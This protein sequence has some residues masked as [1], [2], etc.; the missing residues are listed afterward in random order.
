MKHFTTLIIAT[1]F[2]MYG[3]AQ[4]TYTVPFTMDFENPT[5]S[6]DWTMAPNTAT[7]YWM[8]GSATGNPGNS[9]YITN[10]GTANAYTNTVVSHST[11]YFTV[12][13]GN[14]FPEYSI[15]FDWAVMA[16]SANWDRVEAFVIPDTMTVPATWG[17]L[18]NNWITGEG[19]IYLGVFFGQAAWQRST[20]YI[21]SSYVAN[22]TKKVVFMFYCDNSG[23]SNPVAIDNISITGNSC[24]TPISVAVSDIGLTTAEISWTG[25]AEAAWN[26]IISEGPIADFTSY[27]VTA[28]L[29][30]P[31]TATSLLPSTLYYVYVQ[32]DCGADGTSNWTEAVTFYTLC[33]AVTTLPYMDNFDSYAQGTKPYCWTVVD[34]YDGFPQVAINANHSSPNSIQFNGYGVQTIATRAFDAEVNTMEVTFWLRMANASAGTFEV[35]VMSDVLDPTTFEPIRNITPAASGTTWLYI[36]VQ[37]NNALSGNHF[38][39]L[40]QTATAYG[41]YYIDDV[42][43][44]DLPACF[45]PTNVSVPVINQTSA[46]ITWTAGASESAWDVIISPTA[47]SDLDNVQAIGVI[48]PYY[49]ATNLSPSIVY[50]VYVRA[51]CGGGTSNWTSAVAFRTLCGAVTTLPWADNFD[52]YAATNIPACWTQ[53]QANA[54]YP[55]VALT[56]HSTPNGLQFNGNTQIIATPGFASEANTLEVGFW[57]R[58]GTATAGTFEVGVMSDVLDQSTFVPIRDVTPAT[59][60]ATWFYFEVQLNNAVNG[61]HFIAFKQTATATASYYLDDV[62]V[63]ELP[64]CFKPT[65]VTVSNIDQASVDIGWAAGISSETAWNVVISTSPVTDFTA[66]SPIA[67]TIPYYSPTDLSP[68][69]PYYV[70][71]QANCG[72]A[73]GTSDWT[74]AIAFRTLCGTVTSAFWSDNFDSYTPSSVPDCWT[75]I[76]TSDGFPR[77]I[78]SDPLNAIT[79]SAPYSLQFNGGTQIIATPEFAEG[80]NTMVVSFWLRSSMENADVFEVGVMSDISDQTSYLP[81]QDASPTYIRNIWSHINVSLAGVPANYHYIA[82]KQTANATASYYVDDIEIVSTPIE[83]PTVSTESADNLTSTG[84]TLHK[85]VTAGTVP[86]TSEG[87]KYKTISA[88]TWSNVTT[89][90]AAETVSGLAPSTEYY[91][92]AYAIANE[93]QFN[94]DTLTFTTLDGLGIETTNVEEFI[95]YPNPAS[96]TATIKVKGLLTSAKITVT[97]I[98]GKLIE[99]LLIKAGNDNVELDVANYVA[100]TYLVRVVSDGIN[101]VGKLTVKN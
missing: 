46:N 78:V 60:G 9:L 88:E 67:V 51:D 25:G 96:S 80:A 21:H 30:N 71:V 52:S 72:E 76:Q 58:K 65:S 31:Y 32:A 33:E 92:F 36:E 41:S 53:V 11:A 28:T 62:D 57:L 56:N 38:I 20:F 91:F 7:N 59:S 95:I 86:V 22:T 101:R 45:K 97:D 13:F 68:S 100:G 27:P 50:Y 12:D 49:T 93:D 40:R 4:T 79:R 63:H 43:V 29:A 77:I 81:V 69:T 90:N 6:T 24:G 3:V 34:Q 1:L 61:S 54:G 2:A 85:T 10:D 98:N 26:V 99:T 83:P 15:S 55:R 14:S 23:G 44:H 5:V 82:F 47:I 74:S 87:F 48:T 64:S 39:A 42:D 19:V 16:E 94:G 75:Q 66:V 17:N 18:T 73:D 70:Y 8:I 35:G 37:L 84:A 89:T